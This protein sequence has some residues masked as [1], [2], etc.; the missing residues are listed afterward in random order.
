MIG[1]FLLLAAEAEAQAAV[2]HVALSGLRVRDAMVA[3]PVTVDAALPLASFIDDVFLT[4]RYTAYPVL[5]GGRPAGLITYRDAAT[6]RRQRW[7]GVVVRDR[8]TPLGAAVVVHRDDPLETAW[9]AL[10][11]SPARH[12]L[13]LDDELP[14]GLLSGTDVLRILDA[15]ANATPGVPGRPGRHVTV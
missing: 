6:L 3:T 9:T 13:V 14:P 11:G 15:R 10:L 7:P 12:A 2:A 5:E 4:Y 8:M 1:W